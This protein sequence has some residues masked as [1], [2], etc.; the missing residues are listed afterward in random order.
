MDHPN[1]ACCMVCATFFKK[2]KKWH[3]KFRYFHAENKGV[4][5]LVF[6]KTIADT[7]S[8]VLLATSIGMDFSTT[9]PSWSIIGSSWHSFSKFDEQQQWLYDLWVLWSCCYI[10]QNTLTNGEQ[11][12]SY[13]FIL[14]LVYIGPDH[15]SI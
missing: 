15:Q 1:I 10:V 6:K 9:M 8:A 5:F 7:S 14:K 2:K 12:I 3:E 11:K 4:I 13:F